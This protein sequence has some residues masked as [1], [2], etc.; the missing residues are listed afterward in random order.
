MPIIKKSYAYGPGP[1][2][3]EV[4]FQHRVL[5]IE[6]TTETRNWSDTLDY[7]DHRSTECTWALVWLG[8]RG[9]PARDAHY[10]GGRT[11]AYF[12]ALKWD[13]DKIRDLEVHEQFAWV[14]CTNLFV[15]RNGY[16]LVPSV[17]PFDM[18]LLHG[19]P[20]MIEGLAVWEAY[21]TARIARAEAERMA[22][23]A[24][25]AAQVAAEKA[26]RD[27]RQAKRDAKLQAEKAVAEGQLAR[28][29]A[30]GTTVTVDGFTGKVFWIG[31]SK[32]RGKWNA[33]AGVKDPKGNVQWVPADKF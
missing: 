23:V 9:V 2:T 17:D 19:G 8:T 15:D 18:Q 3:S 4:Y 5:R 28:I 30:K 24:E 27:A 1:S 20:E 7:S 31:V 29:P 16:S 12:D 32:Y 10:A 14:D 11:V 21:H 26:K 6:K 33:R 13:A 25:A 22:K